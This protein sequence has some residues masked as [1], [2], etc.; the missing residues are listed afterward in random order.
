MGWEDCV[1]L[2]RIIGRRGGSGRGSEPEVEV[3]ADGSMTAGNGVVRG[4]ERS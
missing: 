1:G 3:D 4:L 2:A